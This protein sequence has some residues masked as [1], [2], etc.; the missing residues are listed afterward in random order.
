MRL[1]LDKAGMAKFAADMQTELAPLKLCGDA[2]PMIRLNKGTGY[3][4]YSRVLWRCLAQGVLN[5]K[6]VHRDRGRAVGPDEIQCP[7]RHVVWTL[8]QRK[9][10]L[11][12]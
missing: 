1:E 8:A 11:N 3:R 10:P 12:P 5:D 7:L 6:T 4:V 9:R 2:L